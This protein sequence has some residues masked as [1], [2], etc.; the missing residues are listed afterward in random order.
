[1]SSSVSELHSLENLRLKKAE[2]AVS[3]DTEVWRYLATDVQEDLVAGASTFGCSAV[4]LCRQTG[5]T[6]K[7]TQLSWPARLDHSH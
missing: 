6:P 4:L 3:V 5:V 1:M 2:F 7:Q